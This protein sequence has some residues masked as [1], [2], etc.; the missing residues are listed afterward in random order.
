M[1]ILNTVGVMYFYNIRDFL[2][3]SYDYIYIKTYG[4]P[5]APPPLFRQTHQKCIHP[6]CKNSVSYYKDN[7]CYKHKLY[8]SNLIMTYCLQTENPLF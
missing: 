7:G 3:N 8:N 5:P 1:S 6:R 4:H 2:Q